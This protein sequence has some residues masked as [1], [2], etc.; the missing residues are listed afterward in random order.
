MDIGRLRSLSPRHI[1]ITVSD[2]IFQDFPA[3]LTLTGIP[4]SNSSSDNV[5]ANRACTT[6]KEASDDQGCEIRRRSRRN[7]PDEEQD[8]CAEVAGH[9]ASVLRQW[10]KKQRKDCRAYVP[11]SSRPVQPWEVVLADTELSF[12]LDVTGTIGSSRQA[13]QD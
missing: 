11:R 9:A 6:A 7:E 4:T 5:D 1:S 12:H 3:P 13:G 10:H 2:W 8:V